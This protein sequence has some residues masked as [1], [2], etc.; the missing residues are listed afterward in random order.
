MKKPSKR[1]RIFFSFADPV[2]FSG[3]KAATELVINGLSARG[4]V[5]RRLPLPVLR[6]SG[7]KQRVILYA[8]GLLVSWVRALR[9]TLA[10]GSWLYVNL[11]Q[12]RFSFIRDA[13]PLLLG[14][15]GLGRNRVLIVLH[16]SLFMRW[17][18]DSYE[19]RAFTFLLRNAGKVA[20]LG[21][22]Q[23]ARLVD[24]G[25]PESRVEIV[26]NSCD[27]DAL[28][29]EMVRAKHDKVH[30]ANRPVRFLF[31][32]S[33]IDTKGYPEFLEAVR[34]LA[35]WG[36]PAVDAVV[37]GRYAP[38]LFAD[39]LRDPESVEKWIEE[40]IAAINRS[41]RVRARW[42]RGA[43]GEEKAAL[44]HDADVFVLPTRYAVEA[45]PVALLEAM[46]SGC[47]IVTSRAGE[48]TTILDDE[49]AILLEPVSADSVEAALQT[50]SLSPGRRLRLATAA[51]RRYSERYKPERHLD[52]WESILSGPKAGRAGQ[53]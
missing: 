30:D 18:R 39:R 34:R 38:S 50:L 10:R 28:T 5:C 3:Q 20:V 44:F 7:R 51:N 41:A 26:V 52:R 40:R 31:L 32:G 47:A 2:G 15:A 37:C 23:K 12:T 27:I 42:V 33:L 29:P 19:T 36:G 21:D 1:G 35:A 22:S 43:R 17:A 14:R 25:I 53:S 45:Q 46:A 11:G 9:L 24:L 16:G 8:V 13:V 49:S 4:W 48:I 6:D